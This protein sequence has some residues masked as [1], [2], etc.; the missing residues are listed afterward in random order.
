MGKFRKNLT[1]HKINYMF[2]TSLCRPHAKLASAIAL[3]VEAIL[4]NDGG[5]AFAQ[6]TLAP[7]LFPP[8]DVVERLDSP[9]SS[10]VYLVE[11]LPPRRHQRGGDN[12]E[13]MVVGILCRGAQSHLE[14]TET[15]ATTLRL[16]FKSP[17]ATEPTL[18][19]VVGINDI[20][21]ERLGIAAALVLSDK[22][23]LLRVDVGVTIIYGGAYAVGQQTLNDGRRAGSATRMEQYLGGPAR[24]YDLIFLFLRHAIFVFLWC[25]I[26]DIQ[27]II[28]VVPSAFSRID[29]KKKAKVLWDRKECLPLQPQ[30]N[31][32][33]LGRSVR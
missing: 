20:K 9:S 23:F 16:V 1:R 25:K 22:V 26:S 31:K 27:L 32:R 30:N 5:A 2:L 28:S 24:H 17:D 21:P 8:Y 15:S 3:V 14:A 11:A 13:P 19:V 4:A 7:V 6:P 33:Y 12:G 18:M 29:V 10:L